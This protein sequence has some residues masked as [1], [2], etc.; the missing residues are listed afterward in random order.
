[1]HQQSKQWY[2][3]DDGSFTAKLQQ[4]SERIQVLDAQYREAN[5][6]LAFRC[7]VLVFCICSCSSC[8]ITPTHNCAACAVV[9]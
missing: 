3:L 7:V 9:R 8:G 2:D 4:S 1:M 5:T 6:L